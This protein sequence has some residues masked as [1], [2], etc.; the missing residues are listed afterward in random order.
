M[1][2]EFTNSSGVVKL[3]VKYKNAGWK[4]DLKVIT[5]EEYKRNNN[6]WPLQWYRAYIDACIVGAGKFCHIY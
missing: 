3:L 4:E 2:K 1:L 6:D 5:Y